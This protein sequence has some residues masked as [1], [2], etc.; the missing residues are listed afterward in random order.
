MEAV[1]IDGV[2]AKITATDFR[3]YHLQSF[4]ALRSS[5]YDEFIQNAIDTVYTMFTGVATGWDLQ[6][7]QV[8]FDKTRL[9]YLHLTAW[10][11]ADQYP[12]LLAGMITVDWLIKRKKVDGVD[13]TFNTDAFKGD[14]PLEWLKSNAFG[15][16]ALMMA[17]TMPRRAL[18]RVE[19]FV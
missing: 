11:I 17:A 18:L 9:C 10:L 6:T 19:K 14:S 4:P 2:P 5:E 3:R 16:K 15:R 12:D 13:I 8:W 1:F 7:R